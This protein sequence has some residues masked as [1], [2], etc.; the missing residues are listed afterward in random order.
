M[1][2]DRPFAR[3]GLMT[4]LT[5]VMLGLSACYK[6]AGTNVQPTANRVNIDDL[7]PT[8]AVPVNTPLQATPTDIV[9]VAP[10]ASPTASPITLAP[11]ITPPDAAIPDTAT[12]PQIAP[13]FTPLDEQDA[14]N[15][16]AGL[17]IETPGMSD[18]QPSNTP[19]P[20]LDPSL[21][22]TPTEVPPEDNP[23]LHVVQGGD[24][25]YSIAQTNNVSVDDLVAANPDTLGGSAATP[26]QIGWPLNLPG[27]AT[28]EE[29]ESAPAAES[30]GAETGEPLAAPPA[31]ASPGSHVVQPGDTVYSI[32]A[33]YGTSVDAIIAANNL[34]VQGN[35]VYITVGQELV[36]PAAE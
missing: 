18:I 4:V 29:A 11:T 27:C 19:G 24:T 23:C 35:V 15:Q 30:P 32:A 25:L 3:L 28:A 34:I 14:A 13:S 31:G 20:T 17:G 7:M 36:I 6:N 21:Q 2:T 26:L 33:L 9:T 8:T 16:P 5:V 10:A 1:P 22:P 12:P